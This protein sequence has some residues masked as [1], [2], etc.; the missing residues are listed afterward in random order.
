MTVP[1]AAILI[2]FGLV[3]IG[4]AIFSIICVVKMMRFG[5]LTRVAV[6]STFIYLA[7]TAIVVVI[8]VASLRDVDWSTAYTIS[9]PSISLPGVTSSN[10]SILP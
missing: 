9:I 6:M 4:W 10:T 2:P 3:F 5:F 1:Y 8:G 7:F